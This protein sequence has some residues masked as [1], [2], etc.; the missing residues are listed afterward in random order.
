[1]ESEQW[2]Y[3]NS[4]IVMFKMIMVIEIVQ[5]LADIGNKAKSEIENV[6]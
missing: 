4:V 2:K 5:A 6:R 1:M 3:G